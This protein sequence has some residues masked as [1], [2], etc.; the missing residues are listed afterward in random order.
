[1]TIR[2]GGTKVLFGVSFV[3]IEYLCGA[4]MHVKL[5]RIFFDRVAITRGVLQLMVLVVCFLSSH[6]VFALPNLKMNQGS[7]MVQEENT[8]NF[9][10]VL[11]DIFRQVLVKMS[12]SSEVLAAPSISK[13]LSQASSYV[14]NYRYATEG[15]QTELIVTFNQPALAQLLQAA[16]Q[17]RWIGKRPTTL[18][19]IQV[20][21]HQSHQVVSSADNSEIHDT[22]IQFAESRG[23]PIL[24]PLLDLEDPEP[25]NISSVENKQDL[26][27]A[28][29]KRYGVSSVVIA[30][31]YSS[32]ADTDHADEWYGQWT[33]SV[34]GQNL[35]WNDRASSE[36]D[37]LSSALNRVTDVT[38]GDALLDGS[39]AQQV[40]SLEVSRITDLIDYAEVMD[41][42]KTLPMV[43]KTSLSDMQGSTLYVSLTIQGGVRQLQEALFNSH[44][45]IQ[46]SLVV[47]DPSQTLHYSWDKAAERGHDQQMALSS[48][49]KQPVALNGNTTM[50]EN[51]AVSQG[52]RE[53][54]STFDSQVMS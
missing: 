11:P 32:E 35:T 40:V 30:G 51:H 15:E 2:R 34:K 52:L 8:Q 37:L 4:M 53:G 18:F 43:K 45:L 26:I 46:D 50:T 14:S 27:Q 17:I 7:S 1:M 13:A 6:L 9:N 44:C 33:F 29:M 20:E 23:M 36:L 22:L 16:D 12:G 38:A 5:A 31:I 47:Q 19:W 10:R 42:L 3:G 54:N 25:I 24:L 39:Q 48:K 49:A 28:L 21:D 41:F